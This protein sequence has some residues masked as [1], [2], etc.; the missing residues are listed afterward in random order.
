MESFEDMKRDAAEQIKELENMYPTIESI[1]D[2][3]RNAL[4]GE[5]AL[6]MRFPDEADQQEVLR[7]AKERNDAEAS[8]N[9]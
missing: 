7:I 1:V 9:K 3:Y 5:G 6:S 4:I 8:S 2:D